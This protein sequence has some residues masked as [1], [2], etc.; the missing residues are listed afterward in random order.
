MAGRSGLWFIAFGAV[1]PVAV[2]VANLA[3]NWGGLL[4]TLACLL[5]IGC[6]LALAHPPED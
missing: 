1:A 6:A 2:L 3:M 4:V 5:W